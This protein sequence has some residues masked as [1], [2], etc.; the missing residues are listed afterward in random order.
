[1]AP[2]SKPGPKRKPVPCDMCRGA[3]TVPIRDE[4][5]RPS[6]TSCPQCGGLGES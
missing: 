4:R 6:E 2:A 5:G 3:G 1:M